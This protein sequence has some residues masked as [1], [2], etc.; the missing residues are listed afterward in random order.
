[1]PENLVVDSENDANSRPLNEVKRKN[2]LQGAFTAQVF[3]VCSI[4]HN[5]NNSLNN[6]LA[7]Y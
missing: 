2:I 1:M 4:K 7:S 6:L 3:A 5:N